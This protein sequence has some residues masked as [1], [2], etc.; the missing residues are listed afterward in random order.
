MDGHRTCP[1]CAEEIHA[2]ALRCPHCRS[3]L[4][5][6][7]AQPWRR[8]HPDRPAYR[9]ELAYNYTCLGFILSVRGREPESKAA[10]QHALALRERPLVAD[11]ELFVRIR[12]GVV[13]EQGGEVRG[14]LAR[15]ARDQGPHRT[16]E[17]ESST[18][19]TSC[20]SSRQRML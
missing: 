1:Y 12:A 3:H 10:K 7:D 17:K 6:G 18:G 20:S 8:D 19:L 14:Q 5:A 11:V 16:A 9:Q 13:P 2:A 15:A 4:P